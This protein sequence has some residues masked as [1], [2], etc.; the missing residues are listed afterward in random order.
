M[1]IF[2]RY[3]YR[4]FNTFLLLLFTLIATSADASKPDS[5]FLSD[6]ILDIEL[7]ADFSAIQADRDSVSKP[8]NGYLIYNDETA[9]RRLQVSISP[10]G[11]FRRDPNNC[12]FPPLWIDF[13]KKELQNTVFINQ[14]KLKLVTPCR[15][16]ADVVDEYLVYKLYNAITPQSLLVRLA[17]ITYFDSGTG[18]KILDGYG[19]FIEDEDKAAARN[20][21]RETKKFLTPFDLDSESYMRLAL[22]QY[23]IGNKDWFVS[24][25]KNIILMQ[26]SDS[27]LTPFA[28]PYDFDFSG[29]VDADYTRPSN[30]PGYNV[31]TRRIYKGTCTSDEE[32]ADALKEFR[33]FRTEL[34]N[35]MESPGNLPGPYR[36]TNRGYIDEFFTSMADITKLIEIFRESC[37]TP[38]D[39]NIR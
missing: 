21:A 2:F 28:V 9:T 12:N 35:I 25:K 29:F 34:L 32:F 7:R 17:H 22:F 15:S 16:D 8:R 20:N 6:N 11:N 1:R 24:S 4:Y 23:M 39:Y 38:K 27:S 26:P 13:K 19:F 36:Q 18:K 10:R 14:N 31:H 5:L 33:A 3:H 37:E 30:M